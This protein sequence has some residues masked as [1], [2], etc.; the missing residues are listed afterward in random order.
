MSTQKVLVND[1]VRI[2]VRFVDINPSTG[3]EEDLNPVSVVVEIKDSFGNVVIE[4]DADPQDASSFYYD[5][6]PTSASEYNVKFSG[7]L[8]NGNTVIVQQ[9]L[10]VSTTTETYQ[11]LVT[12]GAD[13]HIVFAADVD[14]L[15]VDPDELLPYFPDATLLEIG[16]IV[17]MYSEEVKKLYKL[18]DDQDVSELPTIVY[19]YIKAAT[20][21]D[22]TRTYGFGGDDEMSITL[23]DLSINNR[24]VPRNTVTRDNASTWCQI[25]AALRKELISAKVGPR[26]IVPRGV[27]GESVG[28]SGGVKD[29]ETGKIV[30][31][32][33]RE[34]YGPGRQPPRDKDQMPQRDLRSYD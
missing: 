8:D 15:Y 12:L 10:Y 9:K 17:H 5:F 25:S 33:D 14:P 34:L 23:G 18:R 26:S 1:T 32:S 19:D 6:I 30:Y 28:T 11:P 22:L 21:C 7:I 3:E 24:N 29:P 13:E 31:L 27:P 20:A 4:E 16:E 2:R